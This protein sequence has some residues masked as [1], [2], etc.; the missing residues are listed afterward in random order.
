MDGWQR[1]LFDKAYGAGNRDTCF[2]Q[3]M[4]ALKERSVMIY[5]AG[6]FGR[7]MFQLLS[8]SGIRVEAFLDRRALEIGSLFGLPVYRADDPAIAGS[9]KRNC[10]V[11][12]S[13]VAD[14]TEREEALGFIRQCGFE[15]VA[16]G[17][18]IRCLLV[19]ADDAEGG[20]IDKDYIQ[21]REKAIAGAA[22]V[23]ADEESARV[24]RNN[25]EAH[26]TRS[27]GPCPERPLA[28]QYFPRDIGLN[29]G[30]GRF[31]DC[32][33]YIGDTIEALVASQG[34]VE[35][36][37]SLEPN[38]ESFEKLTQTVGSLHERIG[39]AFL[40][41]C[42]VS[43]RTEIT[44]FARN[45]GSSMLAEGGGE[46]VLSVALDDVLAGFSP[47]FLKMDIEGQEVSALRGAKKT[48]CRSRPDLAVCVYH[49][50][51]HLWDIPLL[52]DSWGLGYKLYLRT[53]NAYTME[54]VLYA[55][56]DN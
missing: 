20:E 3:A 17:Q 23:F 52:L 45:G 16:D 33:G 32:G 46:M 14:K 1:R 47:T 42:A 7:E 28:E 25:V 29:K 53:Y 9:T 26:V 24:Y 13:I 19:C 10:H 48:I 8:E 12:L 4:H 11:L 38:R 44:S 22:A 36:V 43:E 5:G 49:R 18:S 35:T 34:K 55:T 2:N 51:N 27:Y 50:I 31:I 21:S 41:P 30:F 15:R 56:C 54:T 37:V 40:Y 6:S 39:A